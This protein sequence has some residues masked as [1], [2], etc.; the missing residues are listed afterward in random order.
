V[1]TLGSLCTGSG[2]LKPIYDGPRFPGLADAEVEAFKAFNIDRAGGDVA[3]LV[4]V[5]FDPN[6]RIHGNGTYVGFEDV[7][8][9][10]Q[11]GDDVLL[12]EPEEGIEVHGRVTMID[13][14]KE[15]IYFSVDWQSARRAVK[16]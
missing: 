16:R 13:P 6:V 2:T 15:I 8:G 9:V 1:L 10:V 4:R 11:L 14:S 7:R 3:D 5:E 12:Y